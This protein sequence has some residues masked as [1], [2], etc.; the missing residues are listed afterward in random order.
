MQRG[1]LELRSVNLAMAW[2]VCGAEDTFTTS[3]CDGKGAAPCLGGSNCYW[4]ASA[5][6]E[7]RVAVFG[8]SPGAWSR[9]RGSGQLEDHSAEGSSSD[10]RT[11]FAG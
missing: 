8:A 6:R 1:F 2:E 7:P 5:P 11:E 3:L 10:T 4:N 9:G